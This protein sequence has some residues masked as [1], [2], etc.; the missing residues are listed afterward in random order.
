MQKKPLFTVTF[1]TTFALGYAVKSFTTPP[2]GEQPLK[3]ATGIGGIFFTCKDPKK[4]RAWYQ[5][6]LGLNTNG[7]G[8]VF[9][10][11]QGATQK[12]QANGAPLAKKPATF[13]PPPKILC[14]ITGWQTSMPCLYSSAKTL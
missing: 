2:P 7:Y 12:G 1:I 13:C 14:S 11:R 8:A 3:K 5:T 6:H 9:E 10:W 4:V